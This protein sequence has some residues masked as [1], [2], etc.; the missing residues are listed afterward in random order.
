MP[1][2]RVHH[3]KVGN[4]NPSSTSTLRTGALALVFSTAEYAAQAWC[5]STHTRKLDCALNDTLRLIT[6][7][8]RPTPTDLLPFLA[9]IAPPRLCRE[10][11]TDKLTCRWADGRPCH[12]QLP[13][14]LSPWRDDWHVKPKGCTS[15]LA[16]PASRNSL[17]Y[18][19]YYLIRK[20]KINACPCQKLI[21]GMAL[22]IK[23]KKHLLWHLLE[24]TFQISTS[25]VYIV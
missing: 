20:K 6:G 18:Y 17:M 9:G 3:E 1:V 19:Y 23:E 5:R 25:Y 15:Q 24:T 11:L 10:N 14:Y 7:C 4:L 21:I 22:I 8:L 13:C 2:D 16:N 12:L